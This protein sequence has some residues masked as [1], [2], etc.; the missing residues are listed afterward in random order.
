MLQIIGLLDLDYFYAQC[1]IIKNPELKNKPVVVVMQTVREN[2]GAVAT[3]NYKA[4][5]LKIKS[6]M[7][8]SLAKK[9][10]NDQTF[11]INADKDYYKKVS[12]TI[13]D[14]LDKYSEK[15]EQV[16]IDEAYFDLTPQNSFE[17][18]IDVCN[19]IKDQI[20]A[21][22]KITCSIGLSVNKLVA[23]MACVEKKPNGLTVVPQ[24]KVDSF[25]KNKSI[26]EISGIG[27]K[28]EKILNNLGVKTISQ[29]KELNKNELILSFGQVKGEQI[30]NFARGQD[31]RIINPNR[32]KK[33]ISRLIT[34][35]KDTLD[36]N[37]IK[38]STDFLCER[39]FSESL[40]IK[41]NFKTI[42]IILIDT[43][44]NSVSKSISPLEEINSL[45]QL[46]EI[47]SQLL[48]DVL[49]ESLIL[50]KRVGVRISNFGEDYGYQKK[51][52]DF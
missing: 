1:E 8:L 21:E 49:K 35:K 40:N 48:G 18:A 34:L 38:E 22:T 17:K 36:F 6:G 41:K 14:I 28:S 32:E 39:V 37:E 50:F 46:K 19:K 25:L 3:C 11:F 30:Y 24:E 4:R 31:D 52:F 13:F 51:L 26:L 42:S 20:F 5:D 7:S 16:S 43:K 9:L 44:N 12:D 2:V 33:Q 27:P 10:A 47:S 45:E 23:K 15:V 29:L